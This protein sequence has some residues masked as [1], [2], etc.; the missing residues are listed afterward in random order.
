[1]TS[2]SHL[3]ILTGSFK[4][5]YHHTAHTYRCSHNDHILGNK[6]KI[7]GKQ[8]IIIWNHLKSSKAKFIKSQIPKQ[9]LPITHNRVL[10]VF[11]GSLKLFR[12]NPAHTN[13]CSHIDHKL[14][15]QPT[16]IQKTNSDSFINEFSNSQKYMKQCSN[17]MCLPPPQKKKPTETPYLPTVCKQSTCSPCPVRPM[18]EVVTKHCPG[19]RE[20]QKHIVQ[21]T[22]PGFSQT[23]D[24][25]IFCL[26][27]KILTI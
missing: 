5:L 21:K 17:A 15:I 22:S 25:Y 4:I 7:L 23:F 24:N 2:R 9:F 10:P 19:Q 20:L 11:I 12:H 26:P 16:G 8:S 14:G 18:T 3:P 27:K 1:M 13:R 6:Q